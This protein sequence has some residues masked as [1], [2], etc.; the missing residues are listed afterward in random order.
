MK[1]VTEE[2]VRR[3]KANLLACSYNAVVNYGTER[4]VRKIADLAHAWN[5][6]ER[7][8]GRH[9]MQRLVALGLITEFKP[10]PDACVIRP[11]GLLHAA[12]CENGL[13]HPVYRARRDKAANELA[14]KDGGVDAAMV[15]L[16]GGE[17]VSWL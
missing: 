6:Y 11:G 9:K 10:C 2:E 4:G 5:V 16:V 17:E 1:N 12:D 13:N 14:P 8:S 7:L 15:S 3:A